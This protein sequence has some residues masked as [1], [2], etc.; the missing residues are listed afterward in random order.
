MPDL[1][2]M[3][4]LLASRRGLFTAIAGVVGARADRVAAAVVDPALLDIRRYVFVP[5]A[6][7]QDVAVVDID[8][9]RIAS[10]LRTGLAAEKVAVSRDTAT[11]VAVNSNAARASLTNVFSGASQL[12]DLP[13]P[14]SGLTIGASGHIGAT[15]SPTQGKIVLLDLD[16]GKATKTIMGLS[17]LRDVMFGAQDT[18]LFIAAADLAGVGVVDVETAKLIGQ[19]ATFQPSTSGVAALARAPNGREVLARPFDGGP[20]SVLDPEAGKPVAELAES[21]RTAGMF[22]SG[23]GNYLALPRADK[24]AIRVLRFATPGV[25]PVEMPAPPGTVGVYFTWLDS[26]AFLSSTDSNGLRVYD[27][28][29]MRLLDEVVL[30]GPPLPGAVTPD[31]R[32]LFL[33]VRDPPQLLAV[34]GETHRVVE[35]I[36]LSGVPLLATVAGGW[37]V[38][39]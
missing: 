35:Q 18:Q 30:P 36:A 22:P 28:D 9:M 37:G 16:E 15:Y 25:A 26:I 23:T 31:S 33:P 10:T 29:A 5:Y 20:I 32:T 24:A 14:A 39:H 3:P 17:A 4:P 12:I 8:T 34:D 27:L 38:C 19:I 21:T 13:A 7:S 11:L 2:A 6:G 1:R